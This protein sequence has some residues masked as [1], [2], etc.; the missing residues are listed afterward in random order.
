MAYW[1]A[2]YDNGPT[3]WKDKTVKTT[4][5]E[6][7]FFWWHVFFIVVVDNIMVAWTKRYFE[8][9]RLMKES[10]YAR[11]MTLSS[12][13]I[14]WERLEHG[15]HHTNHL[16]IIRFRQFACSFRHFARNMVHNIRLLLLCCKSMVFFCCVHCTRSFA[17]IFLCLF[18]F[19]R[20]YVVLCLYLS[21]FFLHL[22]NKIYQWQFSMPFYI[23]ISIWFDFLFNAF[24]MRSWAILTAFWCSNLGFSENPNHNR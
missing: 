12:L 14:E 10:Q 8:I 6:N 16:K 20:L 9:S 21:P 7:I 2:R 5:A 3:N 19:V 24:I 22:L 18:F 23:Y 17:P 11:G 1:M 15:N 4:F 13:K